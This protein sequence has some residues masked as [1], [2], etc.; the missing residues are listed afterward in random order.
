MYRVAVASL[1]REDLLTTA[2]FLLNTQH[3]A[4]GAKEGDSKAE[5]GD[6]DGDGGVP[7]TLL[8]GS[9]FRA[10]KVGD[11]V[12]AALGCNLL[13]HCDLMCVRVCFWGLE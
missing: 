3:I 1:P 11:G 9:D 12:A 13:D 4:E 10:D 6:G 2:S 8:G 5:D 7:G